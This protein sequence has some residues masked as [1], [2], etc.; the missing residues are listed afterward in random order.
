MSDIDIFQ[1]LKSG[2]IKAFEQIYDKY[3]SKLFDQAHRRLADE[4]IVKEFIQ[5]LFTELWLNKG[6]IEIHTS[7]SSYLQ[8]S[9]KFKIFNHYKSQQV[10]ERYKEFV[11]IQASLRSGNSNQTE[12]HLNYTDLHQ[13]LKKCIEKL[14][15]QAQRV[16]KLKQEDGL[17]YPEIAALLQISISTVEKHIIR[18]LKTIR[19]ELKYFFLLLFFIF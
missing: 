11:N 3:W 12:E 17:T 1:K 10:Q 9:L 4:E 19:E 8:Q 15:K 2:D 7:L 16:Y 13:A 6:K 18:A 5:D 14:P